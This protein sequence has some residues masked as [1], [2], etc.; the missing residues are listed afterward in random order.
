[1]DLSSAFDVVSSMYMPSA[2]DVSS[3]T[4]TPKLHVYS[5]TETSTFDT[6]TEVDTSCIF[7]GYSMM[8]TYKF[9]VY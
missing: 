2:F 3:A 9:D 7:D 8:E 6:S 4:N 5:V 1:M